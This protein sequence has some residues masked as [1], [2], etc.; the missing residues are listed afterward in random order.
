MSFSFSTFIAPFFDQMWLN[1][2]TLFWPLY[3][4][5]FEK[6]EDLTYWLQG[7]W[8]GLLSEPVVYIPELVGAVILIWFTSTLLIRRKAY[9][10]LKNGEL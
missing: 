3:G 5:A 9:S 2:G 1:P 6:L 7:I 4:F 8:Q 10:F